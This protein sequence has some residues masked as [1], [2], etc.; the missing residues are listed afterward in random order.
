AGG[1]YANGWYGNGW[2]WDP[3]FSA[4]T[5]IPGD[6]IFYDPFGWGFYS[7]W[8]AF[9]APYFGYGFGYGRG[10]YHHFGPGYPPLYSAGGPS[11]GFVGHAY[12]IRG[13]A[14]GGLSAGSRF[15]G[16]GVGGS[17]FRSA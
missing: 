16:G 7:P 6:G 8:L 5:F 12:N 3:W 14:T 17:G 2:Y 10:Y 15:G 9:G 11:A 13:G 4:Y 1:W